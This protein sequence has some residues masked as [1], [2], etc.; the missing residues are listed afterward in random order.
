MSYQYSYSFD[1][2][3]CGAVAIFD[4]YGAALGNNVRGKRENEIDEEYD[5]DDNYVL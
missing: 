3:F 4:A 5:W 2:R 1:D